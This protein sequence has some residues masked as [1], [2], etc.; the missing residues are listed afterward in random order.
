MTSVI[1]A[2]GFASGHPCPHAGQWLKSFD[3]EAFNGQGHGEFT[4]D[5]DR[6]L[7]FTDA[8]AALEFWSRQSNVRPIRP[9]GRP[10]K[11]M[12]ALTVEIETLV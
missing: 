3:H 11:P 1:R 7:H 12:T 10:N 2:V 9:D 4:D 6:A 5:I 8:A